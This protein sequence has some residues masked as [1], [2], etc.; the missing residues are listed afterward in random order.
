M[1]SRVAE[2]MYWMCRY[3]ERAENVTRF[4]DVNLRLTLELPEE[5]GRWEPLVQT[6]EAEAD[7]EARYGAYTRDA[8]LRFLTFDADHPTSILSCLER[9]RE[10]ARSIREVISSEMWEQINRAY[11]AVLDAGDAP[12]QDLR[13]AQEFF[14][15]VK[16]ESH[17]FA[18]LMDATMS[19]VEAWHFGELGRFIERADMT[20]RMLDVKYYILLPRTDDVGSPLDDLQWSAVLRS[21]SGLEMFRKR[22]RRPITPL[23][24]LDFL[25]LDREFPRSIRF[26]VARAEASLHAISGANPGHPANE[27][28]R[29][30]GR[31]RAELE[32]LDA[33]T[34]VA[35]GFH[36]AVQSIQGRLNGAGQAI[37]DAFF[38]STEPPARP[39]EPE[40]AQ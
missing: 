5:A 7:F 26:S 34:I 38:A 25:V 30:L 24:V 19:H 15:R 6:L 8:V 21:A 37:H 32:D 22:F 1:L 23:D 10:N 40:A 11:L 29:R 39:L 18:G 3:I 28:E 9:A 31:L 2:S 17:L 13:A 12:T 36:E 14:Q 20:S 35:Q 16:A 27:A 33:R 4:V